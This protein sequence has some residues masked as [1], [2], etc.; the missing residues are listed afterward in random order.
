MFGSPSRTGLLWALEGLS[1]NPETLPSAALILAR[2]AEIEIND[3]WVNKPEHSLKAIFRCWMPQTAAGVEERVALMKTIFGKFPDVAWRICVDQFGG[4][5]QRGDYSHK[6]KWRADGYGFGEP[7]PNYALVWAFVGQ[8]VELALTRA[9]Y[10]ISMLSD[11]IDRLDRLQAKDQERVWDLVRDWASTANDE[12]K[13]ALREKIRVSTLSRRAALRAKREGKT[14]SWA[15]VAKGV[16]EALEPANVMDRHAWLF[17]DSW[18]NESADELEDLENMDHDKRE[19][20][21]R[22]QRIEALRDIFREKGIDG[23]LSFSARSR[24]QWI[25]GALLVEDVLIEEEQMDLVIAA[26][27]RRN[28]D[29]VANRSSEWLINGIFG[30]IPDDEKRNAFVE[31]SIASLGAESAVELLLLAPFGEVTWSLVTSFGDDICKRY[32]QSVVPGWHCE[33]PSATITAAEMLMKASRPRAAYSVVKDHPNVLPIQSLQKLLAAMPSDDEDPHGNSQADSYYIELAFKCI[34]AST[35]LS[36]E[37]KAILEF[38]Y[39]R[40]LSRDWDRRPH[41]GIPNLERYVE[42]HPELMVQAIVWA[43]R[44]KDGAEDPAE[45]T[46]APEQASVMAERGHELIRALRRVPG[47]NDNGDIDAAKLASWICVVRES[48]EELS[49]LEIADHVIGQLLASAPSDA[50]GS[51]PCQSVREVIEE[52]RS[53]D[54]MSGTHTG[55]YNA[56]GAHWRGNGG[57]QERALADKYRKWA[58]QV[59]ASSPFV[60]SELLMRLTKTYEREAASHDTET[61]I[62][63]RLR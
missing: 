29:G 49:R 3:N 31:S 39:I 18:I 21:I 56:R 5:P 55:V 30:A 17:K 41:S 4:G 33:S 9:S 38:S 53:A 11:L 37:Q 1:W 16:Y 60:A 23:L 42:M 44:R 50:D 57:D 20:R 59:R 6:P 52:I 47:S 19:K 48:C 22:E 13:V 12:G 7:Y 36:L 40:I 51:W 14:P 62:G 45:F 63:R 15:S 32:W 25:I 34:D 27:N 2:L 43:Y 8:M 46:V 24:A 58:Q 35:E 28:P 10:T 26:F 54:M 61:K